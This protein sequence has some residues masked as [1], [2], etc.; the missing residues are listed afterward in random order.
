M[1]SKTGPEL[2]LQ[3][4]SDKNGYRSRLTSLSKSIASTQN[5]LNKHPEKLARHKRLQVIYRIILC[6]AIGIIW[7]SLI[8][9]ISISILSKPTLANLTRPHVDMLEVALENKTA[10]LPS[11][12]LPNVTN[13]TASN[14][15]I[16][17]PADYVFNCTMCVPICGLWHPL[18][19]G[20]FVAYRV[21]TVIVAVVDCLFSVIGLI[22]L[23]K[24]PGT[25]NFPQ[26][27]Y[28]FMFINSVIFSFVLA[29]A[30]LPGPYY[31]FCAER[32]QSYTVVSEDSPIQVTILGIVSHLSFF[33][34][35]LWFLCA[36][37]NV[38][39]VI[40][41]PKWQ[42]LKS[43]KHKIIIFVIEAIVSFGIPPL[44]PIIYLPI[45]ERYSFLRLPQTAYI[46]Q[47]IPGLLFI[48]LPLLLFTAIS[49]TIIS[50]TIYKLQ[51]QKSVVLAG[52]Q[53]IH[54]KGYEIRLIIFAFSLGIVVFLVLIGISFDV[55]FTEI[56]QFYL[57]EFW[58]CLTMKNNLDVFRISNL[59]CPTGYVNYFLP[60]LHFITEICGGAWSILLLIILTTKETRDAWRTLLKKMCCSPIKSLVHRN[61]R[62]L[63]TRTN[64][65]ISEYKMN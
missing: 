57:E 64:D 37:V 26:I 17:C 55:Y 41:F 48:V 22:L 63:G 43:Q 6:V 19:E 25:F 28:L 59:T 46:I 20:F 8:G 15:S 2:E 23:L 44:F 40:Y 7:L 16:I 11:I 56:L 62:A 42:I 9:P 12:C 14:Y 24:V 21:E 5:A 51:M 35:N 52:Q 61:R 30:A 39:L 29:I 53:K 1:D 33:S 34:F 27:N 31:F 45:F 49:L 18:G 38:F 65:R 60:N 50:L 4:A 13:H 36:T 32:E 54:L 47:P 3:G 58:S 10:Y